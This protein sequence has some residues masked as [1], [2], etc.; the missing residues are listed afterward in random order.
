MWLLLCCS[1]IRQG[2]YLSRL[3]PVSFYSVN[4][5]D[6]SYLNAGLLCNSRERVSLG[7]L[8]TLRFF[9][10]F[11]LFYLSIRMRRDDNPGALSD[12]GPTQVIYR[13]Q[14]LNRY[15]IFTGY[16]M[17]RFAFA[18]DMGLGCQNQLRGSDK[19]DA[20]QNNRSDMRHFPSFVLVFT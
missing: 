16:G 7:N 19:H 10:N 13:L 5:P 6:I 1:Y 9:C 20:E 4:P 11:L 3:Y 17:K 18:N 14:F 12:V 2:K 8:V 15:M